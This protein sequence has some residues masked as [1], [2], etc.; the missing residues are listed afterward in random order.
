MANFL[1]PLVNRV[2]LWTQRKA[3]VARFHGII[4]ADMRRRSP[5]FQTTLLGSLQLILDNDPRRF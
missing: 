2:D 4:L 5:H 3:E 1:Q